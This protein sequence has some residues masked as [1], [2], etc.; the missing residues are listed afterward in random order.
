MSAPTKIK[1][2]GQIYVLAEAPDLT[3]YIAKQLDEIPFAWG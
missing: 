3:I 1:Y 2:Q